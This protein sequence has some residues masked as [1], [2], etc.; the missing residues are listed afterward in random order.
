MTDNLGDFIAV[1]DWWIHFICVICVFFVLASIGGLIHLVMKRV[2]KGPMCNSKA[3]LLGKTVIITGG[4]SGLGRETAMELSLKGAR[5]ILACRD[6]A[7]GHEIAGAIKSDTQG[8][9]QVEHCDLASLSSVKQFAAKMLETESRVDILVNCA[10]VKDTPHWTTGDGFEYQLGVNFISHFLLTWLLLPVIKRTGPGS[11]IV[12]VSCSHHKRGHFDPDN[13]F[14]E[15]IKYRKRAAYA[16][17]KLCINLFSLELSRR[18]ETTGVNVYTAN[19]GLSNTRLGRYVR[20]SSG[21]LVSS[22]QALFYWPLLRP[23]NNAAQTILFCA[24]D[25]TLDDQTGFYYEDCAISH[26]SEEAESLASAEV[27]WR[28]TERELGIS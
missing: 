11:R 28:L 7:R 18:L 26:A 25:E 17:S 27:L 14:S 16:R 21:L 3:S 6:V 23:P 2:M 20:E 5:I 1:S 19:P 22:L 13:L 10:G 4:T 15:P 9:F 24:I 8:E 12:N